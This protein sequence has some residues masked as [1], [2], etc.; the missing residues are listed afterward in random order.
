MHCITCIVRT[1]IRL[2][3]DARDGRGYPVPVHVLSVSE[4]AEMTLSVGESDAIRERIALPGTWPALA[5]GGAFVAVPQ[6][7]GADRPFPRLLLV[8]VESGAELVVP[9]SVIRP[10][11]LIA[12]RLSHYVLWSP[13]GAA[14]AW[15]QPSRGTLELRVW[16][17][18]EGD[19]LRVAAGAPIFAAW[20]DDGRHLAVH[21][22][23]TVALY[24]VASGELRVLATEVGGFRTPGLTPGGEV[25]AWAEPADGGVRLAAIGADGQRYSGP[26]IP[27]QVAFLA[28]GREPGLRLAVSEPGDPTSF[29]ALVVWDPRSAMFEVL[30]RRR[31]AAAFC[32]PS[33]ERSAIAFV[34][35]TYSSDGRVQVVIAD[36]RGVDVAAL[37]PIV[38]SGDVRT[39]FTFFDQ[40]GVSHS[41]WSERGTWLAL[42]GR[43]GGDGFHALFGPPELDGLLAADVTTARPVWQ[44]LRPAVTGWVRETGAGRP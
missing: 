43:L 19:S 39:M 15:V 7:L 41:P 44:R 32:S 8:H 1:W 31:F 9:G 26:V 21:Y 4:A 24:D 36:E 12:E 33:L 30:T 6:G 35:P 17:P 38:P 11:A 42:A 23:E 27:G 20:A 29:V 37:E 22:G 18:G 25:I 14:L 2:A 16:R 10:P 40:F 5:P 3:G 34:V 28:A 13:R